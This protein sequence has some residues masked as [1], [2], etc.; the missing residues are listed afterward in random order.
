MPEYIPYLIISITILLVFVLAILG[1]VLAKLQYL[2]QYFNS[3]KFKLSMKLE[4]SSLT[5]DDKFVLH[6]YNNNLNDARIRDIGVAYDQ[7]SI[8]FYSQLA[9]K[10]RLEEGDKLVIETRDSVSLDVDIKKMYELILE[11]NKG[12]YKL[13][14]LRLYVTDSSGFETK[15]VAKDFNKILKKMLKADAKVI[16]QAKCKLRKLKIKVFFDFKKRKAEEINVARLEAEEVLEKK[17][18]AYA[19]IKAKKIVAPTEARVSEVEETIHVVELNDDNEAKLDEDIIKED[20]EEV[21]E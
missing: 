2:R 7:E 13:K 9:T 15:V 5:R 1:I 6:I 11:R 17:V 8:T 12:V 14:K 3:R 21:E 18:N 16:R 19:P 10:L 20:K 4:V